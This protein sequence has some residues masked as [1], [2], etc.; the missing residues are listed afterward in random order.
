M[1]RPECTDLRARYSLLSGDHSPLWGWGHYKLESFDIHAKRK[2]LK[3]P[4]RFYEV[5]VQHCRSFEMMESFNE[6]RDY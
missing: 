4:D 5:E 6:L 1:A 2:W 3:S